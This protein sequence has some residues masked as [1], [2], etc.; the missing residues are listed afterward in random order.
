MKMSWMIGAIGACLM[1][2]ALASAQNTYPQKPASQAVADTGATAKADT[3]RAAKDTT[4]TSTGEVSGGGAANVP[5]AAVAKQKDAKLI[6][7]PAWWSTHA[8]ADGKPK[9]GGR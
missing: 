5:A 9:G 1:V 4:V 2:P 8:T 3:G 7:S 6:G